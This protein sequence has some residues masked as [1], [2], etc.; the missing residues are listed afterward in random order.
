MTFK[1]LWVSAAAAS[2]LV[3]G[4]AQAAVIT[5]L[6]NT[7]V[8]ASRTPAAN[9]ADEIH[10]TLDGGPNARVA[11]Q[12]NGYPNN[13]WI[14]DDAISSWIGPRGDN[15]LDGGQQYFDYRTTFTLSGFDFHTAAIIG[16]WAIDDVGA[17]IRINGVST[18]NA[19]APWNTWTNFAIASGFQAGVNTIDFI[20]YNDNSFGPTGLRVEM[21]G[22]ANALSAAPEPAAW[23]MML[24]GFGGLGAILR[25]R[26]SGVAIAA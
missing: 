5:S 3:A 26:R 22:S 14:G 11:N 9:H 12:S 19:L 23:A 2:L 21:T 16:R 25:R 8:D 10:Y 15:H 6:F 18:N 13:V 4:S 17:D 20:V 7:G 1:H 24:I